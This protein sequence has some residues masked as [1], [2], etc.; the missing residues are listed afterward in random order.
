MLFLCSIFLG[1]DLQCLKGRGFQKV[2]E[3]FEPA[4][5]QGGAFQK[6]AKPVITPHSID[7]LQEFC[8]YLS[9]QCGNILKF[10]LGTIVFLSSAMPRQSE[11]GLQ[12]Q[13]AK[14]LYC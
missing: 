10:V 1:S 7:L 5:F 13:R 14:T 4:P 3:S 11:S 2:L 6:C 9:S 8:V 12:S